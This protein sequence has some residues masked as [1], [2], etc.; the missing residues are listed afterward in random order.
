MYGAMLTVGQRRS[1]PTPLAE[2]TQACGSVCERVTTATCA[3]PLASVRREGKAAVADLT[4]QRQQLAAMLDAS[5][6][7]ERDH[8]AAMQSMHTQLDAAKDGAEWQAQ[9]AAARAE[10]LAGERDDARQRCSAR[11]DLDTFRSNLDLR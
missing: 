9:D 6:A 5:A 3:V 7:A 4:A 10:L 11:L 2:S 8:G 1:L